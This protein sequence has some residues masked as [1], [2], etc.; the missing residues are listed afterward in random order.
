MLTEVEFNETDFIIDFY[1]QYS[2]FNQKVFWEHMEDIAE[3][4]D[5]DLVVCSKKVAMLYANKGTGWIGNAKVKLRSQAEFTDEIEPIISAFGCVRNPKG[6]KDVSIFRWVSCIPNFVYHYSVIRNEMR[7][8]GNPG[9][10]TPWFGNPLA[11]SIIPSSAK[12]GMDGASYQRFRVKVLKEIVNWHKTFRE[13][14]KGVNEEAKNSEMTSESYVSASHGSTFIEEE[15]RW[16]TFELALSNLSAEE[17]NAFRAFTEYPGAKPNLPAW[18]VRSREIRSKV[19]KSK[20]ADEKSYSGETV[21]TEKLLRARYGGSFNTIFA[22]HAK[23]FDSA[24]VEAY[25]E[26]DSNKIP[27]MRMVT[28]DVKN[29]GTFNSKNA[30]FVVQYV[31]LLNDRARQVDVKTEPTEKKQEKS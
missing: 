3:S 10:L 22:G 24:V 25:R 19:F 21:L 17:F 13:F 2:G 4:T 9:V 18:V 16:K 29:S 27:A 28:L 12:A 30:T 14:L 31:E 1:S 23:K 26:L 11:A 6:P 5:N 20:E 8:L 7:T 15:V